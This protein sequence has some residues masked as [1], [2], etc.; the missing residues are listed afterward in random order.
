MMGLRVEPEEEIEGLDIGEH[1]MTAYPDFVIA[2]E[3][4]GQGGIPGGTPTGGAYASSYSS[5]AVHA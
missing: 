2:S 1:G 3:A 5:Q 4:M